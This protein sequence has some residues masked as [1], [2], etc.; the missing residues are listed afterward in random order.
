MLSPYHPRKHTLTS[1]RDHSATAWRL[2]VSNADG[3][4]QEI[5][6]GTDGQVLTSAG[7]DSLPGFEDAAGGGISEGDAY[8]GGT[9]TGVLYV[10]ASGNLASD[11]PTWDGNML[12]ASQMRAG[13]VAV[14]DYG[15]LLSLRAA[16]GGQQTIV[17]MGN[18]DTSWGLNNGHELNI[19][20]N[21]NL[22]FEVLP[23]T[24]HMYFIGGTGFGFNE[25]SPTA[26]LEVE[27]AA[28]D[29][30][31]FAA[32]GSNGQTDP[33]FEIQVYSGAVHVWADN[34]GYFRMLEKSADPAEPGEGE[35]VIWMSDGT[36]KGDDGDVLIASKG[37]GI[38]KYGTLF[39]HSAGAAW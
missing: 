32:R 36:G 10:D 16:T 35:C 26:E 15:Q 37:G 33:I 23:S 6:L 25:Q 30:P 19:D 29:R 1:A 3:E 20:N 28:I 24:K 27:S 5:G 22:F 39:D 4:V 8:S 31:A 21:G 38:T 14:G 18:G 34:L 2:F 7:V 13:D 17:K 12:Y 11:G 9:N